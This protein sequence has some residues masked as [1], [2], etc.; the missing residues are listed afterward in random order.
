[1]KGGG[2]T[3]KLMAEV[4]LYMLMEMCTKEIGLMTKQMATEFILIWME[5]GTRVIG[6]RIDRM[7]R[8]WRHG[9]MVHVMMV[10]I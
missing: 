2:E 3:Q 4:D 9:L 1:M 7:G 8:E 10:S 6:K 5:P